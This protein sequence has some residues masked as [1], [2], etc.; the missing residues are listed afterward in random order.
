MVKL[1]PP[2]CVYHILIY[3]HSVTTK[4]DESTNKIIQNFV[5]SCGEN[6]LLQLQK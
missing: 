6:G 5:D 3:F 4:Q 1:T 2:V